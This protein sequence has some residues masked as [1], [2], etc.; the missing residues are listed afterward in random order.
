MLK[1]TDFIPVYPEVDDPQIQW[2]I[3]TKKEF[4]E[5]TGRIREPAPKRG[6]Y[7][8]HQKAFLRYLRVYDRVLNIQETGTGKTCAL[9]A[10]AEYYKTH[11]EEIKRVYVLEKGPSTKND[12]KHQ[13]IFNCTAGEYETSM[14]RNATKDT[15]RKSNMTREVSKWYSIMTYKGFANT[16]VD[17]QMTDQEIIDKYSGCIFLVDEGHNLRNDLTSNRP[18]ESSIVD[19]DNPE[20]SP[21]RAEQV[22]KVYNVLWRVFHLIKRSKVIIATATPMINN[23]NEIAPLMNLILPA[24][25]QM[26]IINWNYS[27]VTL[28]Q[29]EPFFRGRVTYVRGL[30]TGAHPEYQGTII[31]DTYEIQI[32]S[33]DQKVPF[34]SA[35]S[36]W[37][38]SN[39]SIDRP[40]QPKV[41]LQTQSVKSQVRV[42]PSTMYDVINDQQIVTLQGEGYEDAKNHR[43]KQFFGPERDASCFVFPDKSY[44][45]SFPRLDKN[46]SKERGL[47]K[48]VTSDRADSYVTDESFKTLLRDDVELRKL[49]CKFSQIMEI[50]QRDAGQGNCFCFTEFRTGSGAILLGQCFEARGWERFDETQSV[51]QMSLEP[52][53]NRKIKANFLQK[54]RFGLLTSDTSNSKADALLE[55]FNCDQNAHGEYCQVIIGSPTARDGINLFNVVRAFLVTPGWHPSG[56]H[57]ALSR[58]LRSISHEALLN[59][60]RR[61]R[62][63]EILPGLV[64]SRLEAKMERPEAEAQAL[65]EA[66]LQAK[67]EVTIQVK[68]YKMA[69]IPASGESYIQ[70]PGGLR[71]VDLQDNKSVDLQLYQHSERKDLD[72]KRMM[73]Y[74]KR[75]AWDALLNYD[76]NVRINDVDGSPICDYDLC[77]YQ[78]VNARSPLVVHPEALA[79]GQGPVPSEFDY[80]TYDIYYSD[81]VV[82]QC[83]QK[84]IALVRERGSVSFAELYKMWVE[85]D[86]I[87]KIY[88]HMAVE[89]LIMEKRALLDRFGFRCYLHT[90]GVIV[91][92]QRE[93]PTSEQFSRQELS[94]YGEQ[95]VGVL[96]TPFSEI[97]SI[98]QSADQA[99]IVEELRNLPDPDQAETPT[100]RDTYV[101]L[102]TAKVKMLSLVTKVR[103]LEE[104]LIY[105]IEF[106]NLSN[107]VGVTEEQLRRYRFSIAFVNRQRAFVFET[108]EPWATITATKSEMA[109]PNQGRGRRRKEGSRPKIISSPVPQVGTRNPDNTVVEAVY[110]HTLNSNEVDITSYAVTSKF[111]NVDGNIRIYKP[112]E[113]T[114]W[115]EVLSYEFLAYNDI[116]Q[117]SRQEQKQKY[118]KY[119]IYGT[120]FGD[121]YMRI[122]DTTV[123]RRSSSSNDARTKPR[124]E[125]CTT[126]SRPKLFKILKSLP[127]DPPNN[128]NSSETLARFAPHDGKTTKDLM[129]SY[130]LEKKYTQDPQEL[131]SH[132]EEDLLFYCQWYISNYNRER[133]CEIVKD[134][135]AA[136]DM[137]M[138]T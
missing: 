113:G 56:M 10:L 18:D 129:I 137:L 3:S 57:Q 112:S 71:Q 103:L 105:I 99:R 61:Q 30:D 93:F 33:E 98:R 101:N 138:V 79:A 23:V 77:Q 106:S 121:G 109:K 6:E 81:G 28:S 24:N 7:Y 87:R 125:I 76:R 17:R 44:G 120:L 85:S 117:K 69:S 84:I 49:S 114:G 27:E 127:I 55:L 41:H 97:V 42:Y 12:F 128:T 38:G 82:E 51:F 53:G 102:F 107:E 126:W 115:R 91:Y 136:N 50:E 34:H 70:T 86:K 32:P 29:V 15:V 5:V 2:T 40:I 20:E 68:I 11:R 95:L 39:L 131:Y 54:R 134:F 45:G 63:A 14:V 43:D 123:G 4:T 60:K 130:L 52:G 89:K 59:E 110:L 66:E 65:E 62:V 25:F 118:E 9:V 119:P 8:R 74:L 88:I 75:C 31:K 36:H 124:G 73:R 19:T 58:F 83:I 90:D 21:Q 47:G 116:I 94:I 104:S 111:N 64:Q 92:T 1:Y 67:N 26:P 16:I 133:I 35:Q 122:I 96:S 132:S 72:I 80:S 78:C 22:R 37:T 13:I 100:L 108:P 46:R 48:F 135:F